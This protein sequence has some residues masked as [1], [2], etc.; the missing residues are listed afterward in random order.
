MF[1]CVCISMKVY[2]WWLHNL[3]LYCIE[4]RRVLQWH[5]SFSC[6]FV[7]MNDVH[8]SPLCMIIVDNQANK[9]YIIWREKIITTIIILQGWQCFQLNFQLFF[10]NFRINRFCNIQKSVRL[11]IEFQYYFVPNNFMRHLWKTNEIFYNI[12]KMMHNGF[13]CAEKIFFSLIKVTCDDG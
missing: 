10:W 13:V 9:F 7:C 6:V 5:L 11:K 4:L 1:A 8:Y 2:P 3:Y 12:N